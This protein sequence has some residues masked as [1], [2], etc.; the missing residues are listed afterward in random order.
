MNSSTPNP[1]RRKDCGDHHGRS[2]DDHHGRPCGSSPEKCKCECSGEVNYQDISFTFL[3]KICPHC[4]IQ[5]SFISWSFSP[6]GQS[7]NS[8]FFYPPQCISTNQ[9]SILH[10][11]GFGILTNGT[12]IGQVTFGLILLKTSAGPGILN[13]TATGF[14]QNGA[15]LNFVFNPF[16]LL[17][18]E[19]IINCCNSCSCP[20]FTN[21]TIN[22]DKVHEELNRLE[23]I[24]EELNE[25]KIVITGNGQVE[26]IN[27]SDIQKQNET[28]KKKGFFSWF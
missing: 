6:L 10:V 14:D 5:D 28:P 15:P 7:F 16:P 8:T 25:G 9:G 21:G 18:T 26:T 24:R 17:G 22:A 4:D 19:L 20:H 1:K 27:I 11:T 23:K 3:A 12:S 13:F 2:C